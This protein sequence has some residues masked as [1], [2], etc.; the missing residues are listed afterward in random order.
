MT[1]LNPLRVACELASPLS[2][3][4]PHLDSLL[5]LAQANVSGLVLERNF[6]ASQFPPPVTQG[7]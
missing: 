3:I 2:G 1:A 5:E 7:S 4:A 6:V